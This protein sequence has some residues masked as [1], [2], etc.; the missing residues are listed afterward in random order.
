MQKITSTSQ[1]SSCPSLPP[2]YREP[3]INALQSLCS[4]LGPDPIDRGFVLFVEENDTLADINLA[5]C[6]DLEISLEGAFLNGN[7][8]IGVVLW[9]NSGDGVTI[10]CPA[11]N[12][13]A[14]EVANVLRKYL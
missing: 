13:Y 14:E 3:I 1:L 9:G 2:P 10:V 12:G 4:I 8:L 5:C 7:C 11:Q 6:R